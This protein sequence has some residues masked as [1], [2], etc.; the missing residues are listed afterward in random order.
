M[1]LKLTFASLR[2]LYVLAGEEEPGV[3]GGRFQG[4]RWQMDGAVNDQRLMLRCRVHGLPRLV[5]QAADVGVDVGVD[6]WHGVL[7]RTEDRGLS[8]AGGACRV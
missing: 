6:L 8:D 3:E 7:G 4:V 5:S 1:V 2:A